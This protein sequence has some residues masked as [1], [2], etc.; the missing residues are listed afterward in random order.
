MVGVAAQLVLSWLLLHLA[1]RKGLSALGLVPTGQRLKQFSL[2]YFMAVFCCAAYFLLLAK[3]VHA[4]WMLN[5]HLNAKMTFA[6]IGWTIKSV[7]FEELL[8]RGALLYL[9]IVRCGIKKGIIVSAICFGAYHWFSFG[10]WGNAVHMVTAFFTTGVMGLALAFSFA[11][12]QSMYLPIALH[13]GWNTV[14]INV[15]SNGPLG[16]QMFVTDT[17]AQTIALGIFPS[18]VMFLLQAFSLPLLAYWYLKALER[19]NGF[20]TREAPHAVSG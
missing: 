5:P 8:F 11:Q 4:D 1:E 18:I 17:S 10:A 13:C 7:L 15:F 12:T 6:G 14:Q 9:L 16:P 3:L 2:G 19:K 20:I